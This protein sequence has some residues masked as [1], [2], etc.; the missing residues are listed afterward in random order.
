MARTAALAQELAELETRCRAPVDSADCLAALT[1]L[2]QLYDQLPD[3]SDVIAGRVRKAF[4]YGLGHVP[5]E[6]IAHDD[7]RRLASFLAEKIKATDLAGIHWQTA[8]EVIT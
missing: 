8:S 5:S 1:E 6:L 4:L 3:Q 7:A 2:L